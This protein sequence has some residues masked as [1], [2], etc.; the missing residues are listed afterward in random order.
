[1]AELSLREATTIVEASL[2]KGRETSSTRAGT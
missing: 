2:K 1:M